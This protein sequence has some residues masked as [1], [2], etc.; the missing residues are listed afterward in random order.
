MN[1]VRRCHSCEALFEFVPTDRGTFIPL[2][3]ATD[4]RGNVSVV[5]GVATVLAGEALEHARL[6]RVPLR[7]AHFATCPDA[8]TY[9]RRRPASTKG[10]AVTTAT[11]APTLGRVQT[12]IGKRFTFEA[13]HHLPDH[14]G[15][16][17]RPHGHS[18]AVEVTFVGSAHV[19]GPKRGMVVDF[20][21]ISDVWKRYLEPGLDHRDL[22]ETLA[23]EVS[24]TTA[25]S[26][27]AFIHLQLRHHFGEVVE[28]VRVWETANAWAEYPA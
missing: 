11:T 7:F 10:A 24:V 21:D 9:R 3:L 22:N 20:G 16:C 8:A 5:D 12:R 15:K 2:D 25:E 23:G 19:D 28:R 13:S 6:N 18:Y 27:A 17:R 4:E 1:A 14:D 26:I